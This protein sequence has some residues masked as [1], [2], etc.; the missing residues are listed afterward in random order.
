MKKNYLYIFFLLFVSNVNSSIYLIDT[1]TAEVLDYSCMGLKFRFYQ[2]GIVNFIY[3][4][5]LNRLN[6]GGSWDVGNI[7]G[8]EEISPRYPAFNFRWR[9]FDGSITFPVAFAIGFD[10]QGYNYI[11]DKYR[12]R[13]KG[14][15]LVATVSVVEILGLHFGGNVNFE[16]NKKSNFNSFFG[17]NLTF[18]NKISILFELDEVSSLSDLK[19]NGGLRIHFNKTLEVDLFIKDFSRPPYERFLQIMYVAKI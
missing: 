9:F 8:K 4:G 11:Q 13:E 12:Q 1:P 19:I 10:G 6:L 3:C 17:T 5:V 16:D 7:I 2:T 18:G 14:I 15:Y